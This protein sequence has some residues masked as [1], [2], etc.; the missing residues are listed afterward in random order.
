M[1]ARE[2]VRGL[3]P[4]GGGVVVAR[5]DTLRRVAAAE[6]AEHE[7]LEEAPAVPP[8]MTD[9]LLRIVVGVGAADLCLL[10]HGPVEADRLDEAPAV[11]VDGSVAADQRAGEGEEDGGDR[12]DHQHPAPRG[13][14][15]PA[16]NG[17][18]EEGD[19]LCDADDAGVACRGAGQ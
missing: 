3:L 16:R 6:V 17:A 15:V 11:E 10:H 18:E 8:R 2:P 13:L 4:G 1:H 12:K 14:A 9:A 5:V 19:A 7:A